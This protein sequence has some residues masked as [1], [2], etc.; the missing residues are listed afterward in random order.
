MLGE[1]YE[2]V[3]IIQAALIGQSFGL[4]SGVCHFPKKAFHFLME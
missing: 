3:P 4:L 1:I 2:D